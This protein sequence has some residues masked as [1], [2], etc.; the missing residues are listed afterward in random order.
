MEFFFFLNYVNSNSHKFRFPTFQNRELDL[1][2][3]EMIYQ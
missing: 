3:V 2:R 1:G